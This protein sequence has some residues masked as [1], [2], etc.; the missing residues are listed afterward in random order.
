MSQLG[1]RSHNLHIPNPLSVIIHDEHSILSQLS[2][3]VLRSGT[4]I[5]DDQ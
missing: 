2:H 3:P 1:G 5:I 4:A